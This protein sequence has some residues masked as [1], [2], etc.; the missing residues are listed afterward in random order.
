MGLSCASIFFTNSKHAEKE[1]AEREGSKYHIQAR[2]LPYSFQRLP[3][4]HNYTSSKP[5]SK[6]RQGVFICGAILQDADV[7]PAKRR[8]GAG[9]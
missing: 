4:D 6:C 7:D 2:E 8:D 1:K 5:N 9:K 3:V